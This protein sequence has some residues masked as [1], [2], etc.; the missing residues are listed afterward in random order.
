VGVGE[1]RVSLGG[2]E[3]YEIDEAQAELRKRQS[4]LEE[5]SRKIEQ[6]VESDFA[7]LQSATLR[8]TTAEGEQREAFN[9]AESVQLQ[10]KSGRMGNLLEALDATDRLFGARN[11]QI[12][13]LKEQY[14][15]QSRLL[16]QIGLLSGLALAPAK[17]A[18][19]A[20]L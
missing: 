18:Q 3:L 10:L 13:A 14:T 5:E 1:W 17:P 9:V 7:A 4:K 2:R 15:A 20:K 6:A 12:Q 11:R 19:Q 8:I 16:G